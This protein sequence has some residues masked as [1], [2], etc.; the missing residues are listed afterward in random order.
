[1]NGSCAPRQAARDEPA[2]LRT[3]LDAGGGF[4]EA[5]AGARRLAAERLGD[6]M[7]LAW[8]DRDRDFESPQHASECGSPG[9]EPGYRVYALHRGARLEV[10]VEDGRFVF[11]FADLA[12]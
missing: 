8:Y 3:G 11:L 1:M 5:M 12:A 7:L 2:K 4:A 6:P 10:D 9:A